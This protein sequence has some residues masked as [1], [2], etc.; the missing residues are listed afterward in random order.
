MGIITKMLERAAEERKRA[1][2]EQARRDLLSGAALTG[3]LEGTAYT[4]S[5]NRDLVV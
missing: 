1:I 2:E 4:Y 3:G 5:K